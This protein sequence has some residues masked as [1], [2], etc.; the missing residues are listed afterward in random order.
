MA[1]ADR[2]VPAAGRAGLTGAYDRAVAL[3]MREGRWRPALVAAVAAD[4]PDG[5]LAVE[6]G[7]GTGSL[8]IALAAARPDASV[9]GVDGDPQ[10][11]ALAR[12]KPG[13]DGVTWREGLA[14]ALPLEDA[15]AGAA[16]CSLVLHH[17][18]DAGKAEALAELGRVLAP[19]G[20]LHVADWGPPGGP[21]AAAGARALQVFD[22]AAGPESLLAGGLPRF[23]AAAGFAAGRRRG[24]LRTVWGTLE[25]W[26]AHRPG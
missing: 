24:R 8:A 14:A 15:S 20:A 5:G 21:A 9:V 13:A 1:H 6:V 25:L 11:L 26:S 7:C 16:V 22:G 10:V 4:L 19:G 12:G 2:Y 17:L 23:L 3:T 18:G